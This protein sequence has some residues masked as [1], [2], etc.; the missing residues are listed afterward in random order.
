MKTGCSSIAPGKRHSPTIN[1]H[2]KRG[3][4]TS[5]KTNYKPNPAS[6]QVAS[7]LLKNTSDM[8]LYY[9]GEEMIKKLFQ[10]IGLILLVHVVESLKAKKLPA[11]LRVASATIVGCHHCSF[12][13]AD[14]IEL[15]MPLFHRVTFEENSGSDKRMLRFLNQNGDKLREADVTEVG[16]SVFKIIIIQCKSSN[17][18]ESSHYSRSKAS[19]DVSDAARNCRPRPKPPHSSRTPIRSRSCKSVW[20]ENKYYCGKIVSRSPL[21]CHVLVDQFT[22]HTILM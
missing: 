2:T 1:G 22:G 17:W 11:E 4:I 13:L 16:F 10:L 9:C 7:S 8:I 6:V 5:A 12:V 3:R 20:L 15:E 19:I 21:S 18:A 14:F